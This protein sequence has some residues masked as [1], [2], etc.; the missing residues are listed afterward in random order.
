MKRFV[1]II[2]M[3]TLL[4]TAG[5][6]SNNE[7]ELFETARLEE[8]QKNHEHAIAL[9]KKIV[10]KDPHGEY[11]QKARNRLKALQEKGQ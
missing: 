5:C 11:A 2:M 8:L 4:I 6:S 10:E 3:I 9:Y 7:K 1:L